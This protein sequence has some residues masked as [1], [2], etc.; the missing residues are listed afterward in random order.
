MVLP[1]PWYVLW[2]CG[3]CKKISSTPFVEWIN[4]LKLTIQILRIVQPWMLKLRKSSLTTPLKWWKAHH[5][6]GI[7][8]MFCVYAYL[9]FSLLA[10]YFPETELPIFL[11]VGHPFRNVSIRWI[12]TF[13]YS[14]KMSVSGNF[15]IVSSPTS[16]FLLFWDRF[17]L[18]RCHN[19]A[20]IWFSSI[21]DT[22]LQFPKCLHIPYL[23]VPLICMSTPPSLLSQSSQRHELVFNAET[24]SSLIT[25]SF[26][27]S[28]VHINFPCLYVFDFTFL[29]YHFFPSWGPGLCSQFSVT[30]IIPCMYTGQPFFMYCILFFHST[31]WL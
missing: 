1:F 5:H 4:L 15:H 12:R 2:W 11:S 24:N 14:V 27:T 21:P 25:P 17:V 16:A 13:K 23:W 26:S 10:G 19:Q 18:L 28:P 22:I 29:L 6:S 8:I 31:W 9:N 20:L 30:S 3:N 7:M